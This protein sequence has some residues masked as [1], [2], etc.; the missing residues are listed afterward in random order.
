MGDSNPKV[1]KIRVDEGR[2]FCNSSMKSWQQYNDIKMYSVH[3]ET[4]SLAAERFIRVLN[5]KIYKCMNS[6]TDNFHIENLSE[7][8][9]KYNDTYYSTIKMKTVDIQSSTYISFKLVI[10]L[11]YQN[12]EI[13]FKRLLSKLA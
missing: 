7:I 8:V 6:I 10:M 1:N 4:K 12:I 9:N 11:K 2:E 13:F 3:N 5:K